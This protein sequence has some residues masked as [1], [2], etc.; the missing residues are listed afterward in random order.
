MAEEPRKLQYCVN[1]EWLTS[2]TDKYMPVSDSSTGEVFAE[3]P[4]WTKDE[5]EEAIQNA[6]WAF[7]SWSG[8]PIQKRTQV[9]FR[10]K[11]LL[12]DNAEELTHLC[13]R[14]LGKNLDEARGEIV[15]II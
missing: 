8:L 7:Q 2:K 9:I 14:E 13:S 10:W 12:G 3:A 15:K 4:C 1:G 5:V 11:Q 6:H